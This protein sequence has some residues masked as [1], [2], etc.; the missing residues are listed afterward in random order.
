M[1]S[2]ITSVYRVSVIL[3]LIFFSLFLCNHPTQK[4]LSQVSREIQEFTQQEETTE[5]TRVRKPYSISKE[6]WNSPEDFNS[7]TPVG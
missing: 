5:R 3:P 4:P 1:K 7:F 6:H 2:T